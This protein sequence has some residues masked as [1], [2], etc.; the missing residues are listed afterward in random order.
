MDHPFILRLVNTYQDKG[1]LYMLLE[2]AL[3]GELFSLLAKRA[4]LGDG[5][6]KF[7]ARPAAHAAA[8]ARSS[9]SRLSSQPSLTAWLIS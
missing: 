8:L 5:M 9:H 2:L 4:P 1:E 3:G 6:G 7:C